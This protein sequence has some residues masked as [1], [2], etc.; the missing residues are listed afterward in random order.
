M[1]RITTIKST[2]MMILGLC[3]SLL[4]SSCNQE[5]EGHEIVVR[6]VRTVVV[7]DDDS[8]SLKT[9]SGVSRS[10]QES[11]LS[12]KVSGTVLKVPANVGD[13]IA[14]G[15]VIA[16]LD[17]STYEL[18]LQQA[19]ASVE[20]SQA[21]ARN[22]S[23][24]YQRTR[25]L[26]AN[27]NASLGDLDTSKANADSASAQL[28]AA[29]KSLQLAQLNL[30]Y[31]DLKVGVDCAIDS[32][33][34]EINENVSTSTEI[35]RVNCSD[36]LEI[37]VAVP[38]NI[39]GDFKNGKAAVIKFDA[40]P[41][42]QFSSKVIEVG[43]GA[44]GVGATFPVTVLLGDN[45]GL[46]I[47]PGLAASVAF[48]DAGLS[49]SKYLLPLSAVIQGD[50]GVF[51]YIVEP[52]TDNPLESEGVTTKQMISVGALQSGGIEVISGLNA[53]DRVVTAGV[54]FV[55]NDLLVSY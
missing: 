19:Q 3:A 1:S 23:A 6:S 26:Y 24:A 48:T 49:Q 17:T 10:T 44:S 25:A 54:S 4:L 20:Q 13:K 7:S 50:E 14:A 41:N 36:E 27:N 51:V 5:D 42:A 35:A 18:Q 12:F 32:I 46:D 21:A 28:R 33:S 38:G 31:T 29:S 34:V 39:I 43:V 22:A 8:A 53:G 16:S 37:E 45:Q 30:S 47:R 55:R 11:K 52:V 15:S 9:F 40:L 2:S